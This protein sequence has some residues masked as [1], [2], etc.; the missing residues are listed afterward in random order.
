MA[1]QRLVEL[2][3]PRVVNLRTLN[4]QYRLV[5]K[6]GSGSYGRVLLARPRAGG[7]SPFQGRMGLGFLGPGAH[8]ERERVCLRSHSKAGAPS[9]FLE[10]RMGS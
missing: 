2:T 3:A 6:L 7:E 5:R 10:A 1:L 8:P 4:A 9:S